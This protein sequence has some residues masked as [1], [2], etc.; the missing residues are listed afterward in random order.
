MYGLHNHTDFSNAS[1]GFSDSSI[2]LRDLVESAK[3]LGLEGIAITDH[4][5]T[6]SFHKA[7][8]L[9]EELDFPVLLGNEIYLVSEVQDEML[10]NNFQQGMYF[11]H[12]LLLSL[13]KKGTQQLWELSSRAWKGAY[14]QRGLMRTTTTMKDIEEII[15]QDKGHVVAS[16][17]CLGSQIAKW[18]LDGI[19]NGPAQM[20]MRKQQILQ[21]ISWCLNTFGKDNFYLE[22]QP[23]SAEQEDQ[24]LYNQCILELHKET[25]VP[26]IITTD[27]HYL[28]KD[29]L[30]L[31]AAYLNS[32]DGGGEREVEAFY[33]TAY[34]M[35]EQ[36]VRSYFEPYWTQEQID[37][38]IENTR[39]IGKRAKR[40]NLKHNQIIP[41][42]R[43]DK[44]W[45]VNASF[46]PCNEYEYINRFVH[47]E[48][49]QDRY[50]MYLLQKNMIN[51]I[52]PLDFK[53]TFDR[54]EEELTEFWFISEKI[55][56]RMSAYFNTM[57]KNIDIIWEDADSIV[58]PGRGS[59]VS[60]IVDYILGIT[61]INPLKMPVEMPFWRFINRDRVE[62]PKIYWALI[63]NPTKGCATYYIR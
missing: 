14:H 17:A 18:V 29:R 11:P 41:K 31:H 40:Y 28:E 3:K 49:E 46:Y 60:S 58:G 21:F 30:R 32:K 1:R 39:R 25:G 62:L 42:I 9:E 59:G 57:A 22:C 44:G 26:Y 24:I 45:Q 48:Y 34:L 23:A 10:R 35:S 27:S 38:G 50:L 55:G 54:I 51:K 63:V 52:S 12:F 56:D 7:K 37:I 20:A 13:D 2:G 53:E 16:S 8:L 6:S 19:K 61:Q 4:E 47:S 33:K 15:G 5:I 43:F 36:E